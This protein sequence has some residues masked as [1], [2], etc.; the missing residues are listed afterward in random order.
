[1]LQQE[2]YTKLEKARQKQDE[3]Y[4]YGILGQKWG[5]RRFQYMD[6]SYTQAGSHI[7]LKILHN[8]HLD[9]LL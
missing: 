1:M 5:V 8:I 4:H 7:S 2:Y 9:V 3:L 6:G